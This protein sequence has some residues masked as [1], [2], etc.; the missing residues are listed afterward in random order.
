MPNLLTATGLF[1]KKK[2]KVSTPEHILSAQ[3]PGKPFPKDFD[4]YPWL[5][6]PDARSRMLRHPDYYQFHPEFR[7]QLVHYLTNGC[8]IIRGFM[9]DDWCRQMIDLQESASSGSEAWAQDELTR[10]AT[11]H[12]D[13]LAISSFITGGTTAPRQIILK[14]HGDDQ[15]AMTDALDAQD[16]G[17]ASMLTASIALE[18]I[19]QKSGPMYVYPRSQTLKNE[20]TDQASLMELVL[21][22][23]LIS[24]PFIAEAGD[25]LIRNSHLI[26]GDQPR[27]L[28][29]MTR[30]QLDIR[31]VCDTVNTIEQEA[32]TEAQTA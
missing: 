20:S 2:R 1:G 32:P 30:R 8:I 3:L 24:Q 16:I 19:T 25:L 28:E 26:Y 5:D 4:R 14:R 17:P 15:A 12:P 7:G 23:N 13:L 11:E 21:S 10:T 6:M 9:S 29:S 31:Y 27:A 22:H 18:R